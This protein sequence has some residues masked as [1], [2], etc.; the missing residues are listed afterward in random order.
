MSTTTD[1]AIIGAGPYGLSLAAHLAAANVSVRVF[2]RPMQFWRTNMPEGMVLKSEGFASN[3]W[4]PDGALTL[5]DFCA[6]RGLPYKDSGLPIPVETF[7]AY[8]EAFQKRFVP[9]LDERPVAKLDR[10]PDGYSLRLRDGTAVTANR[11]VIATGIG[12]FPFTPPELAPIA[13]SLCSHSIEHHSLDRFT[14]QDVLIIG[15]GASGVELAGLVSAKGSHVTVVTRQDRIPFCNPPRRRSPWEKVSAPETGLGTSWR[16]VA[17]VTAPMLFYQLPRAF[18][19]MVVRK[20]LGPAPG[21]TSRAEVERNVAVKFGANLV[22]SGVRDGRARVAFAGGDGTPFAIEA[23]H[24]IAATGFKVDMRR[25]GFISPRIMASLALED[26]TPMLSR[27]FET[28]VPGLFTIGAMAAN[29]FGPLLRFAYGAGFASRR[30]SRYLAR[31]APRH[32]TRA[33]PELAAA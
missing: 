28:S 30:L 13:G 10:D 29:S 4:H 11:V 19:H 25:L 5:R 32:A 12:S 9:M 26:T 20:H 27:Y 22:R 17:C 1:V 2:G 31:T 24:V 18:R 23:D 21:W 7:C 15:G 8:G 6:D 16:S 14:G 33:Y 3:L